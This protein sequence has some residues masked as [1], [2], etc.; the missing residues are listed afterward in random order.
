M[1]DGV[2]DP[3]DTTATLDITP[4]NDAPAGASGSPSA[5]SIAAEQVATAID[6]TVIVIDPDN[7]TLPFGTVSIIANFAGEDVLAFLNTDST[8]FGNITAVYAAA[9]GVLTL[10]SAGTT[11]TLA[12]GR[13]RARRHLHQHGGRRTP[14][15]RTIG[16]VLDDGTASSTVA[17]DVSAWRRSTMRR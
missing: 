16:F 13:R 8:V 4:V 7:T 5:G 6:S 11:A 2:A 1:T 9:G 14:P 3:I 17:T 12:H 15:T 10:T